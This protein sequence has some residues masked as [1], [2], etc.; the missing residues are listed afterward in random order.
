MRSTNEDDIR[1][2]LRQANAISSFESQPSIRRTLILAHR[3]YDAMLL[4]TPDA[5]TR[6]VALIDDVFRGASALQSEDV[7]VDRVISRPHS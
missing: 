4:M 5:R 7:S 2:A 1:T 3:L 6:R